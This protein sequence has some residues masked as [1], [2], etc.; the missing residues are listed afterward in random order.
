MDIGPASEGAIVAWAVVQVANT[1]YKVVIAEKGRRLEEAPGSSIG[2]KL[3]AVRLEVTEIKTAL[4]GLNGQQGLIADVTSL[5]ERLH[6]A[7]GAIALLNS[8]RRRG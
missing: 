4:T 3:D 2:D 1:I 7:E 8:D 5:R 6:K